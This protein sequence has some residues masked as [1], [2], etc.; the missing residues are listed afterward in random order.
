MKTIRTKVYQFN[1]LSEQAQQVAI[2]NYRDNNQDGYI[3]GFDYPIFDANS[4][5]KVSILTP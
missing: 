3:D 2:D 4:Q 1:E 5:N